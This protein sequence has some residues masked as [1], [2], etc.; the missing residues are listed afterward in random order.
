[1]AEVNRMNLHDF[2]DQP[3]PRHRH[4]QNGRVV[5]LK[6]TPWS[7]PF[8]TWDVSWAPPVFMAVAGNQSP[9][10]MDLRIH[11]KVIKL[12]WIFHD[13]PIRTPILVDFPAMFTHHPSFCMAAFVQ[14]CQAQSPSDTYGTSQRRLGRADVKVGYD[15]WSLGDVTYVTDVIKYSM[16][17][18]SWL[19]LYI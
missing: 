8:W 13:F 9:N 6:K 5:A 12:R 7:D 15:L 10:S 19:H 14:R 4:P 17:N 2:G 11:G 3:H 1:M 18:M 16:L